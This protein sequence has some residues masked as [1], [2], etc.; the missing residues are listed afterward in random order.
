MCSSDLGVVADS[1][2]ADEYEECLIKARYYTV[3][4]EPL[5]L[6][7]T[8]KFEPK[9]GFLRGAAHLDRLARSAK[10]FGMAFDAKARAVRWRRR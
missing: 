4:R 3:A 5:S 7:V 6:I 2:E 8:L 9:R 1:A 10:Y